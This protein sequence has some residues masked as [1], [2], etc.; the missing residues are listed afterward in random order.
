MQSREAP[1]RLR[2]GFGP[3]RFLTSAGSAASTCAGSGDGWVPAR[4]KNEARG[5]RGALRPRVRRSAPPG[6]GGTRGS[7]VWRPK[8]SAR[9]AALPAGGAGEGRAPREP[10]RPR[11]LVAQSCGRPRRRRLPVLPGP[12]SRSPV[13]D[14]RPH[15]APTQP[16]GA[17][18][19][20]GDELRAQPSPGAT[21]GRLPVAECGSLSHSALL[22]S[23]GASGRPVYPPSPCAPQAPAGSAIS[24]FNA[25]PG[26]AGPSSWTRAN[27]WETSAPTLGQS[28]FGRELVFRG[29]FLERVGFHP[30]QL[31]CSQEEFFS[32]LYRL[33]VF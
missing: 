29:P 21:Q 18:P 5:A 19:V 15:G 20:P 11:S 25:P 23:G 33:L 10:A 3:P 8:P 6:T 31:Y 13:R 9:A 30:C 1:R 28:G 14:W 2:G 22:A 7:A 16:I 4:G 27:K 32:D 12:Q 26:P 17:R 24:R